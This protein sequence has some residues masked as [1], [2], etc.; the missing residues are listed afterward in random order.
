MP[1][2][3]SYNVNVFNIVKSYF[4]VTRLTEAR[5]NDTDEATIDFDE[6]SIPCA[7]QP[8]VDCDVVVGVSFAS[9]TTKYFLSIPQVVDDVC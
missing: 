5:V 2:C 7:S 1:V 4:C 6:D 9:G 3:R 8:T